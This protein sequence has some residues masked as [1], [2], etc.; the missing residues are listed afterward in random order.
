MS[1]DSDQKQPDGLAAHL[2]V[3]GQNTVTGITWLQYGW[4]SLLVLRTCPARDHQAEDPAQLTKI[5][6]TLIKT[7]LFAEDRSAK[8]FYLSSFIYSI[9]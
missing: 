6:T 9:G 4:S 5:T 3:F 8:Q 7:Y 1:S 2:V